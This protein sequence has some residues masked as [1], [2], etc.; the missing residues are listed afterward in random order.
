LA[1]HPKKG[2]AERAHIVLIDETGAL[3]SPLVRRTLA[4]RGQ[5]PILTVK[6]G[7]REKVSVI[8]GLSLSPAAHHLGLYFQ[9]HRYQYINNHRVA[10]FVRDLLKHLRQRLILVWDNGSMHKGDPIRQLRTDFPRVSIEY[11]P[12]Y[13]PELN[14]VEHLWNHVK[15][16]RLANF[17]PPNVRALD[18][19]V[20]RLLRSARRDSP[21][22]QSLYKATPLTLP[23]RT[24]IS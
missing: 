12:P 5:T 1:P 21:R 13:A 18:K 3:L 4:P 23:K 15:R 7:H 10:D 8:A 16:G 24:R 11:L 9:T 22:L 14:P 17:T 19:A 20:T 6:S 2:A